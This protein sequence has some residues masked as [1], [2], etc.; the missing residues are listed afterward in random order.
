MP[1]IGLPGSATYAV[2]LT[3]IEEMLS[4]LPD[5]NANEIAARD[6][7]DVVYTLY[8]EIVGLS[9]S[10]SN[11]DIT[12]TNTEPSSAAVG[13][14]TQGVAFVNRTIQQ[15]FDD[16]F[17]PYV[18]P[19]TAF[20]VSPSVIEYGDSVTTVNSTWTIQAKKNNI[21]TAIITRPLNSPTTESVVTPVANTTATSILANGIPQLNTTTTF[22]FDVN[23]GSQTINKSANITWGS[24]KYYGSID[25]F[26]L[27]GYDGVVKTPKLDLTYHP[28]ISNAGISASV[29]SVITN[30]SILNLEYNTL[31]S[32]PA[33]AETNIPLN[34][35]FMMFAW[36]T[37]AQNINFF[38]GAGSQLR[39]TAFTKVRSNWS[40]MTNSFGYDG[41]NYDVWVSNISYPNATKIRITVG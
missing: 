36:P 37:T 10:V 24:K 26:N 35:T 11:F 7:R 19:V 16:M 8:D 2:T 21:V 5:N 14:I 27:T 25:L 28:L 29:N 13:G 3:G 6:V 41:T 18:P 32:G 22:Q 15:M 38:V 9:N 23:D 20:S 1:S 39:D 34:N 40:G 17:Y 12:Y 31:S 4:V 30:T 33:L